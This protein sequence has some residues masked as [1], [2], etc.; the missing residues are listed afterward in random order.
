MYSYR[1]TEKQNK[2]V[3]NPS[4]YSNNMQHT[5]QHNIQKSIQKVNEL[6]IKEII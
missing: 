6:N 2:I 5:T 1:R 3:K 4:E